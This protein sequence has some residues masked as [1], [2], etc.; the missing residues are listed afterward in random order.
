MCTSLPNDHLIEEYKTLKKR[1]VEIDKRIDNLTIYSVIA[2]A[3]LL[4]FAITTPSPSSAGLFLLPIAILIPFS[5]IQKNLTNEIL[6][7]RNYIS[8]EIEKKDKKLGWET[9]LKEYRNK[10]L[11]KKLRPR[12]Q[13]ANF[14]IYD[15]LA[16]L[17]LVLSINFLVPL[18]KIGILFSQLSLNGSIE[19]L[20]SNIVMIILWIIFVLYFIRWSLMMINCYSTTNQKAYAVEIEK[21]I[22]N[23]Q[24]TN[25]FITKIAS[26]KKERVNLMNDGWNLVE[27]A[28]VDWYFE[29]P[30]CDVKK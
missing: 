29:K 15:A 21:I 16:G 28:G 23:N 24:Q 27:K 20:E 7:T 26:T 11:K 2:T 1:I 10:K 30:K 9:F 14:L 4:G 13:L 12:N 8:I 25:Q 6:L 5:E 18:N 22:T 17:C 19:F 3:T